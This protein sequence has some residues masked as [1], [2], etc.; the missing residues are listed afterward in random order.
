MTAELKDLEAELKQSDDQLTQEKRTYLLTAGEEGIQDY[1]IFLLKQEIIQELAE[2]N[3]L[4]C[5]TLKTR[6]FWG[7]FNDEEKQEIV[8][9]KIKSIKRN[10]TVEKLEE[11]SR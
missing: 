11:F 8:T 4:D 3:I 2:K 9:A 1:N 7:R 10:P 5:E 6:G